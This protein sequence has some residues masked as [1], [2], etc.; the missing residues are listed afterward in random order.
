[1]WEVKH[2]HS[3][4]LIFETAYLLLYP[5]VF[6]LHHLINKLVFCLLDTRKAALPALYIWL[7]IKNVHLIKPYYILINIKQAP[8]QISSPRKWLLA[9]KNPRG[10]CPIWE[11]N[12]IPLAPFRLVCASSGS[13]TYIQGQPMGISSV[14]FICLVLGWPLEK[15]QLTSYSSEVQCWSC[16]RDWKR[17]LDC[18]S[19][20]TADCTAQTKHGTEE[21]PLGNKHRD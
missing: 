17:G 3:Q 18:T 2:S 16:P 20:A 1:M 10:L 5:N 21:L 15:H 6:H 12:E 8:E 13:K 19:I 4:A 14:H 7:D 11:N 9:D